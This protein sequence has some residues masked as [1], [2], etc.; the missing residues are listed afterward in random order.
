MIRHVVGWWLTCVADVLG[1]MTDV[2][3]DSCGCVRCSPP[4][5]IYGGGA[6]NL[7]GFVP[8]PWVGER[9]PETVKAGAVFRFNPDTTD[10]IARKNAE[11]ARLLDEADEWEKALDEANT[12]L[13]GLR[14][15]VTRLEAERDRDRWQ[16][17]RWW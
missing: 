12:E 16:R 7:G 14:Q 15:A 2:L 4:A 5:T 17:W 6:A 10:E 3:P 9:G 1:L 11:I 13:A 8:S